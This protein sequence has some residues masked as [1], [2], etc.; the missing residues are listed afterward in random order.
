MH[1]MAPDLLL[2]TCNLEILSRKFPLMSINPS[3]LL[4]DNNL[5]PMLCILGTL[6]KAWSRNKLPHYHIVSAFLIGA[7]VSNS[8]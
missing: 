5:L 4:R 3:W 2:K 6:M 7:S 8:A 1:M